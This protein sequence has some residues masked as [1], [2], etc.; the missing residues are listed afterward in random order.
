MASKDSKT[1]TEAK[2]P[3]ATPDVVLK[4]KHP[5][6][7]DRTTRRGMALGALVIVV[8]LAFAI[9]AVVNKLTQ[10]DSATLV[11]VSNPTTAV[12]KITDQG[13]VPATVTINKGTI[14][15]WQGTQTSPVV[16]ASNSYPN[17][18]NLS[19][20]KSEQLAN[21]SNYRYKFNTT[22]TYNYH[23][24]LNPSVNGTIQVK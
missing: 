20:L 10:P 1:K 22:G 4:S 23:D 19:S 7:P 16:I 12:V 24:D 17:N 11:K 15:I 5:L 18:N 8:V 13:F 9:T 21:G 14:V 3:A 6:G 2:M